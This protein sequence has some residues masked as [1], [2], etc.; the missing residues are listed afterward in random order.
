LRETIPI[1]HLQASELIK[2]EQLRRSQAVDTSEALRLGSV[3]ANQELLVSGFIREARVA[4]LPVVLD[5]HSVIDGREGLLEIPS[6]VFH[7]MALEAI[8]FLKADPGDIA[9]R[10]LGDVN[11]IRPNRTVEIL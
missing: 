5:A 3:V 2:V 7:R 9:E 6:S 10:R 8:S 1:L 4:E 11:R